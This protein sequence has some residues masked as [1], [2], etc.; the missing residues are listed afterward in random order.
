MKIIVA[1][2]EEYVFIKSHFANQYEII[3]TGAGGPNTVTTLKDLDKSEPV[4]SIGF[5]GSNNLEVGTVAIIK[6]VALYHP[7]RTFEEKIYHLEHNIP[8]DIL[9]TLIDSGKPQRVLREAPVTCLTS[10]DLIEN[11]NIEEPV[12]FDMELVYLPALGFEHV[13][14][15]KIVSDNLNLHEYAKTIVA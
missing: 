15:I 3:Q 13:S 14:A 9:R 10:N 5:A 1:T 6:D 12:V 7:N 4:L 2:D 8:D 11:T